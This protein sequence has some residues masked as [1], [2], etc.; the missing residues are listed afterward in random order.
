MLF[1]TW[2]MVL[3]ITYPYKDVLGPLYVIMFSRKLRKSIIIQYTLNVFIYWPARTFTQ[4]PTENVC[5]KWRC[6]YTKIIV[7]DG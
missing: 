1:C 2:T 5:M 4:N 6:V 7:T 3:L